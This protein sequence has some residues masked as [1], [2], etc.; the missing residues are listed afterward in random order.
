[1][2]G[3]IRREPRA[4]SRQ[5]RSLEWRV[6]QGCERR[7]NLG[8][9][10]GAVIILITIAAGFAAMFLGRCLAACCWWQWLS[11]PRWSTSPRGKLQGLATGAELA[12]GGAYGMSRPG[13]LAS[14]LTFAPARVLVGDA[15]S[16][17][18]TLP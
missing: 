18:P 1:M 14:G 5:R 17:G 4:E 12:G 3:G 8:Q 15:G 11:H 6:V 16:V 2:P 9:L 7:A 13:A 10:L